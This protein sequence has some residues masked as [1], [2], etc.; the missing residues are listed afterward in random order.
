[1]AEEIEVDST[2]DKAAEIGKQLGVDDD[3]G[4]K[5]ML[6]AD[7]DAPDYEVVEEKDEDD[8]IAKEREPKVAKADRKQL[9]NKEKRE[10]RKKRINEKFNE[11]DQIIQQ[12]QQQLEA[13]SNRLNEFEGRLSSVDK[14][15]VDEVLAQSI[16]SFNQAEKDHM[17]AFREGDG[18]KATKAMRVM[19]DAQRNIEKLQGLKQQYDKLPA[20]PQQA[21]AGPDPVVVNKAKEWASKHDWYRA[22]GG[23]EDS[24]IA[25]AI[26]GTLANEGYDP[27]T[28]DFWDELDDRLEKRGIGDHEGD[29]KDNTEEDIQPAPKRRTAP[30][31]NGGSNR[32]DIKGKK[33]VTLPTSYIN[34]LKA[35]GIWDDVPRRNKIIAERER[36]LKEAN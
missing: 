11:K 30:P 16:S 19:Y 24:E 9:T 17:D 1:M 6:K 12:Q 18:E 26:S 28:N 31:I 33:T 21:V 25:K 7:Q 35:N 13:L 8:R 36:I 4:L 10:L 32:N 29:D 20:K 23:D 5:R 2:E 27:R 14:A 15:K 3:K 22:D 34:M